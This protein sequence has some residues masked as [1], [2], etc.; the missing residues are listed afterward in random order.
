MATSATQ[1][2]RALGWRPGPEGRLAAVGLSGVALRTSLWHERLA[3]ALGPGPVCRRRFDRVLRVHRRLAAAVVIG[4]P[5][6]G[7][8][9][10]QRARVLAVDGHRFAVRTN[11]VLERPRRLVE[12]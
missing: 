11:V 6:G 2:E 8:R 10:A 7:G 9:I 12:P 1:R 3:A 5:S 4:G